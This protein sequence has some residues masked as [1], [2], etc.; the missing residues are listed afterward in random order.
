MTYYILHTRYLCTHYILHTTYYNH[1]VSY[2]TL[3]ATYYVPYTLREL[4]AVTKR[5]IRADE[6]AGRRRL[7]PETD[8]T[9]ER[10]ISKSAALMGKSLLL[11]PLLVPVLLTL[12]IPRGISKGSAPKSQV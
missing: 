2:Y 9:L 8:P 3:H 4:A 11:P 10:R 12:T 1:T 5:G 7:W 6:D